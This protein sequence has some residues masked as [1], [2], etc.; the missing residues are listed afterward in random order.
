M[1][2]DLCGALQRL[3]DGRS[4]SHELMDQSLAAAR[5]PACKH[6]FVRDFFAQAQA[7]AQAADLLRHS[8][9]KG[10]PLQGLAIS[11]KDLF[12]VAGHPTSAGSASMHDALP[13]SEDAP[14]VARL[15]AAGAALI[16]HTNLSEFAFSGVGINPH[17]GTPINPV[18]FALDGQWRVPGGSTSGG[19]VSVATGAAWA[20][21]GSDTGG[22]I[23]IPAALQGLVGFK[24]TARLTS[25]AGCAPPIP[26]PRHQLR[27][28]TQRAR[29]T[30][31]AWRACWPAQPSG[32]PAL[33]ALA[34][35]GS[36]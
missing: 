9:Q 29:C 36:A 21:L 3:R 22:S 27:H 23:R 30:S 11:V 10:T 13:A 34:P 2:L 26:Q 8:G 17:L 1:P 6:V 7:S 4:T 12:D 32:E 24:N 14:C 31:A 5:A 35:G 20:A 16:G 15:R 25:T 19:A 28:H 33:A 18:T